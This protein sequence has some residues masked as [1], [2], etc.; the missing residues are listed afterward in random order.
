QG[1][2]AGT[3]LTDMADEGC[4]ASGV[5]AGVTDPDGVD[6]HGTG[7]GDGAGKMEGLGDHGGGTDIEEVTHADTCVPG[8]VTVAVGLDPLRGDPVF[9]QVGVHGVR[10]V[11]GN[12]TVVTGDDDPVDASLL[13]QEIGRAS[14]RE[15]G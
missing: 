2:C 15:R 12:R 9:D 10:L 6:A 8:A 1:L 5:E 7:Q 14:C 4:S 11:A 13:V 3:D